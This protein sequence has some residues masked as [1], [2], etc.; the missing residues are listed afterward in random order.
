MT[1]NNC[2]YY[3]ES[4][5]SLCCKEQPQDKWIHKFTCG[6]VRKTAQ[7]KLHKTCPIEEAKFEN[8]M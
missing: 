1:C 8:K 3:F 2:K 4:Y 7:K 5:E 6:M